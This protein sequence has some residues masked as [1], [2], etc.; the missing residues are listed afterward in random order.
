[1]YNTSQHQ[2]ISHK[3]YRCFSS[4][5][6]SMY[7]IT[8]FCFLI[9]IFIGKWFFSSPSMSDASKVSLGSFNTSPLDV[10]K[11]SMPSRLHK[12]KKNEINREKIRIFCS[13]DQI[14]K[15]WEPKWDCDSCYI[16]KHHFRKVC[17]HHH[18]FSNMVTE[19]QCVTRFKF[20]RRP[21]R[22]L[23]S[24]LPLI[25]RMNSCFSVLSWD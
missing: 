5:S 10:I 25:I 21:L 4:M 22:H 17:L 12:R 13:I 7:V 23:I 3:L 15:R 14:C 1:M 18:F 2:N 24:Q 6:C 9:L 8:S 20:L 19:S 11:S 16:K